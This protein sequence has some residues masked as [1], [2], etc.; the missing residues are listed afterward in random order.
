M[1]PNERNPRTRP[2]FKLAAIDD[3][4]KFKPLPAPTGTYPYRLNI[5][6]LIP[7]INDDHLS[8]QMAGDTGELSTPEYQSRVI[9]ALTEQCNAHNA[10]TPQFFFHLGDIVYNYGQASEYYRQ[11]FNAWRKYPCPIFAI[12]GNHDADIDPFQ[13]DP[14]Q[15]LDAFMSVF[16]SK[17]SGQRPGNLKMSGDV[18]VGIHM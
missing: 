7:E 2:V 1:I 6:K 4:E 15:S 12:A 14:P 11:F 16:C 18:R 17:K 10:Q 5:N 13:P 8:F 3:Q 9:S